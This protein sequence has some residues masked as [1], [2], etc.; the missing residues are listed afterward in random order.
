MMAFILNTAQTETKARNF[1]KE[2]FACL[3]A[4]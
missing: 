1:G 2:N 3:N 4:P